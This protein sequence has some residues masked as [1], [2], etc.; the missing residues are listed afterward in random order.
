M[1]SPNRGGVDKSVK[2]RYNNIRVS[3]LIPNQNLI[4][5]RGGVEEAKGDE[6]KEIDA[7]RKDIDD[8]I[9]LAQDKEKAA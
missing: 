8:A 6:E 7:V 9:R 4:A 1:N 2:M 3:K 5:N